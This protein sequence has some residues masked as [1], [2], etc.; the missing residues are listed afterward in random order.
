MTHAIRGE[1]LGVLLLA[2][3]TACASS[4]PPPGPRL[5]VVAG[6]LARWPASGNCD[7]VEW[8]APT[9]RAT[10]ICVES[11]TT[12]EITRGDIRGF[13]IEDRRSGEET[14][15]LVSVFLSDG[16]L[17]RIWTLRR[18]IPPAAD[19]TVPDPNEPDFFPGCDTP[20]A[21]LMAG[22]PSVIL[23]MASFSRIR[24]ADLI[25]AATRELSHA[26]AI[27]TAWGIPVTRVIASEIA[28]HPIESVTLGDLIAN[29]SDW[30]GKRVS[31]RG[32]Y[33]GGELFVSREQSEIVDHPSPVSIELALD[34]GRSDMCGVGDYESESQSLTAASPSAFSACQF[35]WVQVEAFVDSTRSGSP[36]LTRIER[37]VA[38]GSDCR[39]PPRPELN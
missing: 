36:E 3:A 22:E 10:R 38:N 32:Y 26:E 25:I 4:P 15:Y 17:K 30:I 35:E 20:Y 21:V 9:G 14:W 37:A 23:P 7:L 39:L 33:A 31:V 12:I 16:I 13:R 8:T 27:A 28:A 1:T 29:P 2:I 11:S 18:A 24:N 5:A 6:R 19:R 34:T